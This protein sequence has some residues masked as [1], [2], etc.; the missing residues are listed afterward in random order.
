MLAKNLVLSGGAGTIIAPCPC[1]E[2]ELYSL[3]ATFKFQYAVRSDEAPTM[4]SGPQKPT[5]ADPV[6]DACSAESISATLF[7]FVADSPRGAPWKQGDTIG[8]ISS[9]G[10]TDT[11]VIRP[12][13]AAGS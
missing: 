13:K 7:K 12:R 4:I 1:D 11:I 3:T 5:T 2:V 8:F 6:G 10:S 9:G